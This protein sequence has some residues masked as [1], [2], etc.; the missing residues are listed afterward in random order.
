MITNLK[1]IVNPQIP[2]IAGQNQKVF[3]SS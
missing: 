1:S 2:I 3:N